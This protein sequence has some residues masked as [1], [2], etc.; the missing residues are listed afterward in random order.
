MLQLKI[1]TRL[2]WLIMSEIEFP[3][4]LPEITEQDLESVL[5]TLRSTWISGESPIIAE[6]E[7]NFAEVIGSKHAIAV[8]NGSTALELAFAALELDPGSEVILPSLTI[9]SCLAPLL[10]MNLKPI[11]VDSDLSDWN[12]NVS[13]VVSRITSKTKAILVVHLY[14][15]A[16]DVTKLREV[17]DEK[18]IFLIE[19]C[20]EALGVSINGKTCGQ[21]GDISTFSFYSNKLV[22]TGEGGMCVSSSGKLAARLRKLRNLAF[23]PEV[24]FKHF[25]LGYNYRMSGMQAALGIS[26]LE[27]VAKNLE[28]KQLIAERYIEKLRDFSLVTWQPRNNAVSRNAYWVFG[29]VSQN[30]NVSAQLI[31]SKLTQEGIATRPFF[32][33]LHLQPVLAKYDVDT[34]QSAPNAEFLHRQGLYLPSGNGYT[35]DK[36]DEISSRVHKVFSRLVL[37]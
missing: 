26:Q 34:G 22:T 1:N 16:V 8:S 28:R 3:V 10:R 36:I 12:L 21:F 7:D 15:L 32:Y 18:G 2:P 17:C 29:I 33:P 11:F 20:A 31:S 13:E 25:E 37:N 5:N 35:I 23:E 30:I 4:N 6:F 19:D 27:R 24:R 14:G 9:I